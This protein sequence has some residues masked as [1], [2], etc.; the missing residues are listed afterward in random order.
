[1]LIAACLF[2]MQNIGADELDDDLTRSADCPTFPPEIALDSEL[3]SV[4]F[5]KNMAEHP[6]SIRAVAARLLTKAVESDEFKTAPEC[7]VP[8]ATPTRAELIYRVEPTVFLAE[9][10]Q[11][12]LCLSLEEHTRANPMSFGNKQFESVAKLNDWIM[13]FSQG[14]GDDGKLLYEQCGGNCSPRYTFHITKDVEKL[15]IHA[16]ILCGLARDKKSDQYTVSTSIRW[17]CSDN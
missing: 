7:R 5:I 16:D 17:Q 1:V 8:C 2:G 4:G 11:Q 15:D 13:E 10:E 12:A 14:R 3:G 9:A 6:E